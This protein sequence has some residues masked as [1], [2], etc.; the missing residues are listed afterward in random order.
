M[1]KGN[2]IKKNKLNKSLFLHSLDDFIPPVE[3]EIEIWINLN[4]D[5][6]ANS[7]LTIWLDHTCSKI[8]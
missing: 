7:Y 1:I 5:I 6:T 3:S 8:N 4:E 2:K